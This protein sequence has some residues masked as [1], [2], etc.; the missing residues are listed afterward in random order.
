MTLALNALLDLPE[1]HGRVSVTVT[2]CWLWIGASTG[3]G[4]RAVLKVQG[5]TVCAHRELYRRLYGEVPRRLY[6]TCG[7]ERCIRPDHFRAEQRYAE[8]RQRKLSPDQLRDL[9]AR[10]KEGA[11]IAE[12]AR[13]IGWNDANLGLALKGLSYKDV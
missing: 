3:V 12:L 4:A 6:N 8:A 9:R 7:A 13:E 5:R 2:G 1:L 11:T 10:W